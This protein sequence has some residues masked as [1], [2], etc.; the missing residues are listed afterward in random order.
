MQGRGQVAQSAGMIRAVDL[1]QNVQAV[2]G[3]WSGDTI[4]R[5]FRGSVEVTQLS[6]IA[7][8]VDR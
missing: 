6:G 5:G 3:R 4:T 7:W 2:H 8:V 1:S